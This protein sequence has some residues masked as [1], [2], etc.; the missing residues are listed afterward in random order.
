M[1]DEPT[2]SWADQE[3]VASL[4][5]LARAQAQVAAAGGAAA[6]DR[7]PALD[8]AD[9]QR[10]E[11]VHA[12]LEGPGPRRRGAAPRERPPGRPRPGD[13]ERL[14]LER[15][16]VASYDDYRSQVAGAGSEVTPV[17]PAMLD[18]ARRELA[19]AW[20]EWLEIRSL[21]TDTPAD[22]SSA[23]P[24]PT[25]TTGPTE[26]DLRAPGPSRSSPS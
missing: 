24:P 13:T 17:D 12:D 16:G 3:I 19:S 25:T 1:S 22:P 5:R 20:A 8:P 23:L 6:H 11:Q 15:L 2:L 26:I 21:T 9:V 18:F 7:A 14:V 10:L 4:R